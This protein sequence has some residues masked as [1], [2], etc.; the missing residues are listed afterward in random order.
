LKA[1]RVKNPFNRGNYLHERSFRVSASDLPGTEPEP[2]APSSGAVPNWQEQDS[3]L[4]EMWMQNKTPAQIA[5]ALNRSV[6]AIMT[7]AARLGLPRR[8]APGRKPGRQMPEGMTTR[9]PPR[10]SARAAAAEASPQAST[11]VC[12][13]CLTSF[14]SLG[15]HNRI[16]STCKGSAEYESANRLPDLD[17]SVTDV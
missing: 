11:R 13:M 2:A 15:R 5:E 7:R 6:A 12:L 16:C 10:Q 17:F 4:R 3:V 9:T 1:L 8:F 14:Q